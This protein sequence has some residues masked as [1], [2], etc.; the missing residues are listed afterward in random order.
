MENRPSTPTILKTTWQCETEK[1][2]ACNTMFFEFLHWVKLIIFAVQRC[3]ITDNNVHYIVNIGYYS[4]VF[5][6]TLT[7]V[8]ITLSWLFCLRKSKKGSPQENTSGRKIT[9]IMGLCCQ[10]GVAWGFAFF[11]YGS[12][13]MPATYIFTILNSFQGN[14]LK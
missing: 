10:L 14:K 7:T 5:L 8:I 2:F 12:F 3:W 9:I 6:F 4:L 13:R 1:I 11:A